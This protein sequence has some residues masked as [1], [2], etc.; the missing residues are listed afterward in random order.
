MLEILGKLNNR[1][2][3]SMVKKDMRTEKDSMGNVNVPDD[4]YYGAQTQRAIDNFKI[5]NLQFSQ[6]FIQS[7]AIIKRSAAIVNHELGKLDIKYREAIVKASDEII[8]GKFDNQFKV[9][10]F[11]TGSGTSSNMNMNEV[12]ANA[13]IN[14]LEN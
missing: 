12:I 4:T 8:D 9:D 3:K 11:Q 6:S 5:S 2:K 14:D 10:I 1:I 13:L 7:L